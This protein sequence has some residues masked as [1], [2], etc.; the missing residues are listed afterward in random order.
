[1][2]RN[3]HSPTDNRMA[4]SKTDVSITSI[5]RGRLLML[6]LI[7]TMPLGAAA[8]LVQINRQIKSPAAALQRPDARPL[9]VCSLWCPEGYV[10][11]SV[12]IGPDCAWYHI[13]KCV[14]RR[15]YWGESCGFPAKDACLPGMSCQEALPLD[16]K[17][18]AHPTACY[19]STD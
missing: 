17:K 15:S 2:P 3:H 16:R 12:S 14:D 9:A 1:M 4:S 10:R 13:G 18:N 7:Y 8:A 19:G 11:R 6:V 5:R